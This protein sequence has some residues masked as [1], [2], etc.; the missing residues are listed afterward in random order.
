MQGQ[1]ASF[2]DQVRVVS[3]IPGD[4]VTK[5]PIVLGYGLMNWLTDMTV[6]ALPFPAG[7]PALLISQY[8]VEGVRDTSKALYGRNI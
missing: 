3:Q 4:L 2:E 5:W 8:L 1:L 7:G 6:S